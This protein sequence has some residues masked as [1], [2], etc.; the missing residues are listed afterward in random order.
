MIFILVYIDS[1]VLE[2]DTLQYRAVLEKLVPLV[3]TIEATPGSLKALQQHFIA[4]SWLDPITKTNANGLALL[5]L[6]RIKTNVKDY[7]V[8]MGMLS[9]V[10]GMDQIVIIIK[11]LL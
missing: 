11:G 8:F 4:K 10:T 3:R 6:N 9:S 2:H 7:D 1:V 5:A